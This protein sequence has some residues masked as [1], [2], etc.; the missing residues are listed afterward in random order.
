[1]VGF[2]EYDRKARLTP[3]LLAIAPVAFLIATLGWKKYP[4][5]A[6]ATAIIGGAGAAYLLAIL[7]RHMGRRIEPSLWKSWNGPPTTRFLRTREATENPILRD[8]WRH[9]VEIMTGLDLLSPPDEAQDHR[10]ADQ[11]IEAAVRQ[12]LYLGQKPDYG[13]V[14][15]ENIQYGF[16]RNLYGFRWVGRSISLLCIGVL[17]VS[18]LVGPLRLGGAAVSNGSMIAGI[19][20]D[21]ALSLLWFVAPSAQR[22]KL[23]AER[24]AKQLFQA[25]V[26]ESRK[27]GQ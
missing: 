8:A 11:T 15:T 4:A 1:V 12:V 26:V 14:N 25:T 24:Y 22:T 23:A 6:V 2:D 21:A 9:G 5:V 13:L 7:V 19:A 10:R 27:A 3:G 20:I 16:E 17:V 18:L